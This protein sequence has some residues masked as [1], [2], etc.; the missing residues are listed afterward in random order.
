MYVPA[1]GVRCRP[2]HRRVRCEDDVRPPLRQPIWFPAA[3]ADD[4]G[5]YLCVRRARPS[6]AHGTRRTGRPR[7]TAAAAE[8]S[9]GRRRF[10][11]IASTVSTPP[12]SYHTSPSQPASDPPPVF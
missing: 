9:R 8:V 6:S 2:P 11:E 3:Q 1:D 10:V 5:T 4:D 12:P 7:R